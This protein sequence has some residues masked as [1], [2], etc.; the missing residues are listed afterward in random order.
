MEN[1]K[2]ENNEILTTKENKI[3]QT[4]NLTI[5]LAEAKDEIN[6]LK[7]KIYELEN[8]QNN[9]NN[10][11]DSLNEK[12]KKIEKEKNFIND[13]IEEQ[14]KLQLNLKNKLIKSNSNKI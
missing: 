12:Y 10:D 3:S 5:S 2:I 14:K 1:L 7:K 9:L 13:K 8:K 4:E 11:L 6:L